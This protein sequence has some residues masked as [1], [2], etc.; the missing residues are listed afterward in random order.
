MPLIPVFREKERDYDFLNSIEVLVLDQADIFLMQNWDH[1]LVIKLSF[2]YEPRCEKTGLR[3]F[4]PGPT[5][6][7]LYCHRRCLEACNFVFRK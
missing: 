2:T 5:Q 7:G 3:G 4:R 1:I 6:I